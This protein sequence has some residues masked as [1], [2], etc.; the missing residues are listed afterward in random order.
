MSGML[1]RQDKK[2]SSPSFDYI[3]HLDIPHVLY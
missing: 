2:Y 1:L 3:T